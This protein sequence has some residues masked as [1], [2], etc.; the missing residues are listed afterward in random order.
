MAAKVKLHRGALAGI[1]NHPGVRAAVHRVAE[2][3]LEESDA[4]IVRMGLIDTGDMLKSGEATRTA[5]GSRVRYGAPYSAFVHEGTRPHVI[6]AKDGGL[7]A[8]EGAGGTVFAKK[9]NHPGTQPNPFLAN[10]AF[11]HRGRVR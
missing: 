4:N 5:R 11:R 2:D 8:F 9:V 1:R 7:L 3:I 10:A 6:A